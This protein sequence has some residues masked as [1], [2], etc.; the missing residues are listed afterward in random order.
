MKRR[1][2]KTDREHVDKVVNGL[3]ED[4]WTKL[5]GNDGDVCSVCYKP[6]RVMV[7]RG[8]GYCSQA[9]EKAPF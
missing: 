4:L 6:I 1:I 7:F 8:T 5:R 2:R 9:C 3:V